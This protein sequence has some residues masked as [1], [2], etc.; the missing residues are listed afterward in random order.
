LEK[1]IQSNDAWNDVEWQNEGLHDIAMALS[2]MHTVNYAH[3]RI[4]ASNILVV[5]NPGSTRPVFKLTG[6]D[7]AI[8]LSRQSAFGAK[9]CLLSEYRTSVYVP[10]S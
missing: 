3:T 9:A 6:L 1:E 2:L 10:T 8:P 5:Y 4:F 7:T